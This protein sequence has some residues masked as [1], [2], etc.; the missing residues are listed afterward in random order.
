MTLP[1]S[2][3]S[4]SLAQIQAEFGGDNPI[5]LSEYYSLTAGLPDSGTI[6]LSDFHSKAFPVTEIITASKTWTPRPNKATYIHIFAFGAGGS[7]GSS[8]QDTSS[9]LFNPAGNASASGGAAGGFSYSRISAGSAGSSTITIGAGG[10]GV[11]SPYD[12]YGLGNTGGA[13][14]FV[15]SGLSMTANGGQGGRASETANVGTDYNYS[16]PASGGTA[17]GGNQLNNTG[18]NS[19]SALSDHSGTEVSSASGGGCPVIDGLSGASANTGNSQASA[20]AKVSDNGSWPTYLSTYQTGRSQSV[21]LGSSVLSF[22]ATPGV[23]NGNSSAAVYGAGS[24]GACG[25]TH[26]S[27]RGGNGVVIIVYEV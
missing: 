21:V 26:I 17:S 9:G 25:G 18:G 16:A 24:G 12:H 1:P 5:S 19:G 2:G 15:G 27:G 10:A 7:G 20:G 13:T 22:D 11:Q 8:E 23:R 14:E 6:K 3:S 4:I